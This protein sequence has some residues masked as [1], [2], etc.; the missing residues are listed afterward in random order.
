MTQPWPA[1]QKLRIIPPVL[2]A[3][4]VFL[5][6]KRAADVI[7]PPLHFRKKRRGK[8]KWI[9]YLRARLE[10]GARM[11]R[12]RGGERGRNPFGSQHPIPS[13]DHGATFPSSHKVTNALSIRPGRDKSINIHRHYSTTTVTTATT[14]NETDR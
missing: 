11:I 9:G 8:E 2:F 13:T 5:W 7:I 4:A 14:E 6:F 12:F 3:V 1:K 10:R